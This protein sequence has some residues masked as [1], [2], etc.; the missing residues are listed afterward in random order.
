MSPDPVKQ[1]Q[2]IRFSIVMVNNSSFSRRVNIAIRDGNELV[3]EVSNILIRPGANRIRFPYTGYRFGVQDPC[4]TVLVNIEGNY[5]PVD[6]ARRFCIQRTIGGW[7]L[8]GN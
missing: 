3:I 7:T 5:K 6:L 4:F 1:G 2:R 8:S